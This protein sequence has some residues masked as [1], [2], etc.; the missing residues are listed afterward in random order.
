MVRRVEDR[1]LLATKMVIVLSEGLALAE[2]VNAAAV[3]GLSANADKTE[4]GA[5]GVDAAELRYGCLDRHPVPVLVADQAQLRDLH[6]RVA[7]ADGVHVVAFTEVARRSR[8]YDSYLADLAHTA[9]EDNSYVGLLIRGPRNR[10]TAATKRL[11][12]F[13]A[14]APTEPTIGGR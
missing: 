14:A 12:L 3:L 10:V 1:V 8:D 9:P 7:A 11:R 6:Q 5:E 2:A 4:L 13:G